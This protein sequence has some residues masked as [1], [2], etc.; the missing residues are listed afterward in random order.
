MRRLLVTLA[1]LVFALPVLAQ[2][3]KGKPIPWA[4]KFFSGKSESPPPVILHDFGTLPQGTVKTYRFK[5][6]NIYAY[7]MQVTVPIPS[8]RCVS[9]LEYSGQLGPRETGHIDVQI[10]TSRVEGPKK[11]EL[12]VKFEGRDPATNEK[13]WSYADVEVQAVIRP[14]ISIKPGAIQFGRVP[15][16]QKAE[17]AATVFY[18]GRQREWRITEYGGYNK[19]I[20]DVAVAPVQVR[21]GTAYQ[22]TASLKPGAPAGAFDDQIV[23]KTNDKESPILMLSV[24]GSIQAPLSIV[25]AGPGNLLKMGGVE[26]GKKTEKRVIIQADKPFKLSDITGGGDGLSA[27]IIRDKKVEPNTS[28][29]VVVVFTPD[30]PGPVKK[31]LTVKTDT[32][33]SIVLTVEGVGTEPK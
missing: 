32:G 1:A 30:K 26:V 2:D 27:P 8:C 18:S 17:Q 20:M 10:D 19:A 21:G 15:A 6:E 3:S 31:E 33:E 23:L 5:M 25:G 29:V 24:N 11:V 12:K 14:D 7:P 9:I 4:N 28:Q 13:F 22:V 16:G